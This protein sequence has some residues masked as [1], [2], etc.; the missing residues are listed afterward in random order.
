[1]KPNLDLMSELNL[2]EI[3]KNGAYIVTPEMAQEELK[4]REKLKYNPFKPYE[5]KVF[6]S[7]GEFHCH[8]IKIKDYDSN[9]NVIDYDSI[10]IETYDDDGDEYFS[11]KKTTGSLDDR[12]VT[13]KFKK[14]SE[15]DNDVWEDYLE[16]YNLSMEYN[17]GLFRF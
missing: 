1:M 12:E 17:K 2:K 7:H 8:I 4:R 3:I 10:Y 11:V 6:I 14:Y 15:V 16:K 13:Y 9:F 5:N